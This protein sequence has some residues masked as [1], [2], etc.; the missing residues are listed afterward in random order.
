MKRIGPLILI[1]ATMAVTAA[2]QQN[3][4][5]IKQQQQPDYSRNTLIQIFA[6]NPL[7]VNTVKKPDFGFGYVDFQALN[8]RW[9]VGYLPFL[10]PMYGS[11]PWAMNGAFGGMPDP[12]IATGTEIPQ[13]PRTAAQNRA[14]NSELKRIERTEREKAKAAKTN[15]TVTAKPDL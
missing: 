4:D 6:E 15:A 7:P 1:V 3:D 5:D 13:T 12:F 8:M 14:I 2:A 10:A 9:R 11:V